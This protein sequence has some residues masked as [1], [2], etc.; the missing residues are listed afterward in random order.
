MKQVLRKFN[1]G[2]RAFEFVDDNTV[3]VL[4]EYASDVFEWADLQGVRPSDQEPG[5]TVA[6]LLDGESGVT[7]RY[8]H[9]GERDMEYEEYLEE[10]EGQFV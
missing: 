2:H 8:L 1:I 9:I 7:V 3:V 6:T 5:I 10:R 4:T